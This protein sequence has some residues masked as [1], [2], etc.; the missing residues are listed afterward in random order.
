MKPPLIPINEDYKWKLLSEIL[1][2][3]DSR[4]S[5]QILAKNGLKPIEKSTYTLK[6]LI[7]SM[8]FSTE[9]SY[10]VSEL[11]QR[12]KLRK[13]M[14]ISS[15]PTEN[16]IYRF[17]NRFEPDQF[18]NFVLNLLNN[19]C[20]ERKT[21]RKS[22]ITD[23]TDICLD[24]N[25]F[26]KKITKKSLE[27]RDFKWGYSPHRGYFIGMKL[28]LALEYPNLKPLGFLINEANVP[29]AKIY[30]KILEELSRRKILR[31][32]DIVY[33]DK[34]YY[35]YS[36]YVIG[37]SKF[38][39]IPVIFPKKNCDFN[40]LFDMI[41]YPLNIFDAKRDTEKEKKIYKDLFSK[42]KSLIKRWKELKA[43][44]SMIEDIFK[45]AK[46]AYSMDNL[47]RYTMAA[48]KKYCS[49]S[50]L[51]IGMTVATGIRD[52]E[53]LQRLAEY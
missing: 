50:V 32:G 40:R 8:F 19:V 9:I 38:K 42:F 26:N 11:N 1:N 31:A 3:F 12:K 4:S 16:Q 52:K 13:F 53:T 6:I 29:E 41:S 43:I 2:V 46:N 17:M 14:K 10:V 37:I 49:L 23:S 28:T 48:V 25:W 47:H 30:Q 44:R 18:L 5:K 36:N 51:L 20:F 33:S 22:I 35:S 15:I 27:N 24:I 7:V 45:L 21:G 34:G 39:I